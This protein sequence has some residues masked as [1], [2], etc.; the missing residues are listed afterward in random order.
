M[1]LCACE[2]RGDSYLQ[3][4]TENINIEYPCPLAVTFQE[5][6]KRDNLRSLSATN[7]EFELA[8]LKNGRPRPTDLY[9]P[10]TGPE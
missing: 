2:T 4:Q 5:A 1:L 3:R 9:W 8:R 7:D 10:P 6:N